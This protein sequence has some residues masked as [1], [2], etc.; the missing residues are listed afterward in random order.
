VVL[1]A[2]SSL[3]IDAQLQVGSVSE[4]VEVLGTGAQVQTENAKVTTQVNSV[5][6]DSLPLVVGGKKPGDAGGG[7]ADALDPAE[8]RADEP[9]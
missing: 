7:A 5:L 6:V 2:A 4:S 8:R 3:R 9:P 1:V